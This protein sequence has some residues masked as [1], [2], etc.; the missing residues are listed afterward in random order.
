MDRPIPAANLTAPGRRAPAGSCDCHAHVFGPAARYAYSPARGYTPP[1]AS[2]EEYLAM[3][4]VLGIER[5]VIVQPS[6]YGT[7]N[8]CTR[9]AVERLGPRG[10]GV[11]VIDRTVDDDELARLHDAG[12]RRTRFNLVSKGGVDAAELE[13]VAGRV[14]DLGW[15]LQLF[16]EDE[17][18][19]ALAPR[20]AR[21]PVEL[22]VDHI[23]LMDQAADTTQP[24]FHALLELLDTGRCWVKLSGAYRVDPAAPHGGATPFAKALIAARP[25]RLVWGSDWPHPDPAG[26]MPDDGRLL[27]LLADW[28]GDAA[29]YQQILVDNPA[30]LYGFA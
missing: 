3:L 4:D 20:L 2:W 18:L 12:F 6:V 11:A 25:D 10:R 14:A 7:D 23:G 17:R 26:A 9:D 22:V 29:T 21:L 15:H 13:S 28:A 24:G 5:A 1:D 27:D 8:A 16:V 30:R 19:A